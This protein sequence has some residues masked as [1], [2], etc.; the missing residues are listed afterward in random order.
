VEAL[1]LFDKPARD[2]PRRFDRRKARIR[3]VKAN[4]TLEGAVKLI[5]DMWT[6]QLDNTL[7]PSEKRF[8]DRLVARLAQEWAIAS[9]LKASEAQQKI[10]TRFTSSK[11]VA[12]AD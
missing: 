3:K 7:R 11:Q 1:K 6:H 8:L 10:R 2:L 9:D 4:Y 5:R 12:A